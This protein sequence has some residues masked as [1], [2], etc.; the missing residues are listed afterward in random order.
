MAGFKKPIYEYLGL[1]LVSY[2]LYENQ[3]EILENAMKNPL[4]NSG[5]KLYYYQ[6]VD[7]VTVDK[8]QVYRVYT[9]MLKITEL[10]KPFSEFMVL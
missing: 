10:P 2:S 1:N 4:S 3:I 6:I 5:R 9:L 8:R 7:T